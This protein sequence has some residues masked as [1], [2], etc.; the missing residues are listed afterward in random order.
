MSDPPG[1]PIIEN[2]SPPPV[3]SEI[4]P[5]SS[6][7]TSFPASAL[8]FA[9]AG[10]S[11]HFGPTPLNPTQMLL[12]Y[13]YYG[14]PAAADQRARWRFA[15]T[16]L[17]GLAAWLVLALFGGVELWAEEGW[18]RQNVKAW[19]TTGLRNRVVA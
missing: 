18:G 4:P 5:P 11:Q 9:H 17:W 19:V 1:I 15:A 16:L 14:D 13:A 3:Y 7:S 12:P 10:P 2:N 8:L 6:A